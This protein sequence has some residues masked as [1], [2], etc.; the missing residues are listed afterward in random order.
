MDKKEG[1]ILI[2]DDDQAVLY[3]AK[4]I[5]KHIF[6]QVRTA[7]HPAEV[8]TLLVK[9]HFDVVLL[10]MNF[11]QGK[12]SGQEGLFW[13]KDLEMPFHEIVSESKVMEL[14]FDTIKKVAAKDADVSVL[15]ENGTGK[16]LVARAITE[17]LFES[18][19]FGHAKG[20]FTGAVE[21]RA[22]RFEIASGGTLF[23]DEIG[24]LS[25]SFKPNY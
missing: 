19:L 9:E 13:S 11:V 17:T 25:L 2:I 7:S 8:M 24:N 23:L 20:A 3:T 16:E 22:G 6:T 5:L 1:K 21:E 14:V 15:G 18:E 4:L 10:D 12:T